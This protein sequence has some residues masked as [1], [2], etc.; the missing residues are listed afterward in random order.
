MTMWYVNRAAGIVA[1]LLLATSMLVGLLLSSRALGKKARPNWLTDLHRGLSGLAVIF[2]GV[3][4]AGAIGDN[5]IHFGAADVLVP[6][7]SGWRPWAMA[8][9][10]VSMYLLL[11]IEASS[12]LRRRIPKKAWRAIH[13]A[14]FPLF[15]TAT[16]HAFTAGTDVGSTLGIAV[17]SLASAAIAFL[18]VIRIR[19]E[20][21][22]ARH[23]AAGGSASGGRI[24]ERLVAAPPPGQPIESFNNRPPVNTESVR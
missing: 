12:L 11:A 7:A 3:H 22:H 10:I 9:G 6:F 2:V 17:A 23:V 18:T 15:V 16:T 21:V 4:V 5:F 24:P 14:S 1:W 13:F 20:V 8:W 19:D